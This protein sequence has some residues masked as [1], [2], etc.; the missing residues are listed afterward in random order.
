M[1]PRLNSIDGELKAINT[2]I[3][4]MEKSI[5]E[6]DKRPNPSDQKFRAEL[7]KQ[8]KLSSTISTTSSTLTEG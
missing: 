7:K 2:R 4:G 8:C 1:L 5:T 3:D 6:S